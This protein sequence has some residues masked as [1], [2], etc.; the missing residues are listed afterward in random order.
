MLSQIVNPLP[1]LESVFYRRLCDKASDFSYHN[2]FLQGQWLWY[3]KQPLQSK[4][5]G[6]FRLTLMQGKRQ[7]RLCGIRFVVVFNYFLKLNKFSFAGFTQI[8]M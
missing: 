5:I 2:H 7:G 6:K 8:V 4:D 3:M 1:S